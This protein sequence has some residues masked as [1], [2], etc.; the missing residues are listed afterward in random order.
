MNEKPELKA[1]A[2]NTQGVY[3]RLGARFD[4]ERAKHFLEGKWLERFEELLP[5]PAAILD[6]GCGVGEPIAHYFIQKGHQVT[7]IDYATSMIEMARQRFP[8]HRWLVADMRSLDLSTTFDG[9][10]GWHSFFHLTPDEQR[11]TL[12]RF[13]AHLPRSGALLLT[14]GTEEGEVTGMVGG[15]VV[16]HSSLSPGAYR[17]RLQ[18]LELEVLD[19]VLEDPDCDGASVLLARKR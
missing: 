18:H 10:I 17:T 3:E 1:V 8:Q 4:A 13:A 11:R 19:F 5:D 9:I 14:V 2:L 6:V 16:Y 12:P 15:E 7:G